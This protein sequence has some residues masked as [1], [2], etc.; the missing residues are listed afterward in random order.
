VDLLE[1]RYEHPGINLTDETRAGIWKQIDP[2]R[3]AGYAD[4]SLDGLDP[5]APSSAEAQVVRLACRIAAATDSLDAL[6][7]ARPALLEKVERLAIVRRLLSRLGRR[8]PRSAFMR[9]NALH[10]GLTHLLVT[11][12]ILHSEE[13]LAR[14]S[15]QERIASAERFRQRRATLPAEVIALPARAGSWFEELE[16]FLQ[17]EIRATRVR[18]LAE[19]RAHRLLEGLFRAYYSDPRILDDYLL[20]RFREGE[21]L[22]FLRDI[23][24]EESKGEIRRHYHGSPRFVRLI[25]DHL[26]GMADSYAEA[27]FRRLYPETGP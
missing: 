16:H 6:L 20:L 27:E 1:K 7:Q 17:V 2:V 3:A 22:R 19:R 21:R 18:A 13:A 14:W 12:G 5:G 24:P 23:A 25:L 26:A 15:E 10:R 11:S 8:Y 4:Q 9:L